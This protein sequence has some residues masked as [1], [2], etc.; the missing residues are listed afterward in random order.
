MVACPVTFFAPAVF[1]VVVLATLLLCASFANAGNWALRSTGWNQ[2]GQLGD[3]GNYYAPAYPLTVAGDAVQ[4]SASGAHSLFVKGDGTLWGMGS[5]ALGQLGAAA[6]RAQSTPV[7]LAS[8]VVRAAAGDTHTLFIAADGSLW[9][10]GSNRYGQLGLGASVA[11]TLAPQKIADDV[12]AV[13]GGHEHSLFIKS[14]GTLWGMGFNFH[15][16]LGDGSATDRYVPVQVATEVSQ[17][18]TGHSHTLILK[19][20]STLWAVG[21]NGRGQ[22]GHPTLSLTRTPIFVATDVDRIAAGGWNTLFLKKDA[23]LWGLGKHGFGMPDNEQSHHVPFFV[24]DD[25]VDMDTGDEHSLF[26]KSDATLWCMGAISGQFGGGHIANGAPVWVAV[27]VRGVAAGERHS[28]FLVSTYEVRF[29]LGDLGTRDGGGALVQQVLAGEAAIP[30]EVAA[31]AGWALAGWDRDFGAVNEAITITARYEPLT[32][33]AITTPPVATVVDRG[34]S[35]VFAVVASGRLLSYQWFEGRSGDTARPVA[36]ASAAFFVTR[37]LYA[38]RDF[39]VRVQNPLGAVDGPTVTAGVAPVAPR[40][41]SATGANSSGQLGDGTTGNRSAP[42]TVATDVAGISAGGQHALYFTSDGTLFAMGN[43]SAGQLGDGSTINRPTPVNVSEGVVQVAAGGYHTLFLRDDGVLFAMG[44]NSSGQLGDGSKVQR[45]TPVQVASDVAQ[46]AAGYTHSLFVKNDGTLWATGANGSHQLGDGTAISRSAPVLV[47]VG[48]SRVSGGNDHSLFLKADGTLWAM[49]YNLDGQLGDGTTLSRATPVRIAADVT[50]VDGG[51]T[52]SLFIKRDRSLW[53]TGGNGYGQLG[54]GATR[55][56]RLPVQI[57]EDVSRATAGSLHSLFLKTD[58]SLWFA[59][60]NNGQ[61][62]P[63]YNY[64][65][66]VTM[67]SDVRGMDVGHA[68]TLL[69]APTYHTVSFD[70]GAHGGRVGGGSL[71]QSVEAGRAAVAPRLLPD[72]GWVFTGWDRDFSNVT[73]SFTTRAAYEARAPR[74]FPE[75]AAGFDL[76]ET[77]NKPDADPDGD[78]LPNLLEYAF[79]VSPV[80]PTSPARRPVLSAQTLEG[81]AV[82]ILSHRRHKLRPLELTYQISSDLQEWTPLEASPV[83]SDPD[84]DGDGMVEEI[85][86]QVSPEGRPRVFLRIQA[87]E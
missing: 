66:P 12:V 44:S 9:G 18:A 85:A 32:L 28:L 47:A 71:V 17:V 2:D 60:Y 48:V 25:V 30:P 10:M 27:G 51:G 45:P 46:V 1:R 6:S 15:G 4:I 80:S 76:D 5:G 65:T 36:G 56:R 22:L 67:A 29:E 43:N 35:A 7:Q 37:P 52:H 59:G 39:W 68:Y 26:L 24:A 78:G 77:A 50:H 75:W 82:L 84:V 11:Y 74:D 3:A 13:V 49:G 62:G 64:P 42:V 70:P 63:T 19:N 33:P 81:S 38:E 57:A 16:E 40:L 53:A 58:G 69:L 20:D 79:G 87:R 8:G 55:G 41:L 14:D 54:D 73:T 21:D 34:D 31:E 61:F 83:V 23:T 72:P 86:V